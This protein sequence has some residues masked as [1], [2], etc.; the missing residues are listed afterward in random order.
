MNTHKC[1]LEA[2]VI[3]VTVLFCSCSTGRPVSASALALCSAYRN[4]PAAASQVYNNRIVQ[5]EG[6]VCNLGNGAN[7]CYVLLS[8]DVDDHG[9]DNQV[10]CNLDRTEVS[11]LATIK[12]YSRIRLTGKIKESRKYSTGEAVVMVDCKFVDDPQNKISACE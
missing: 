5:V 8:G 6:I 7:T 1:F 9:T 2:V 10:I 12:Q 3:A 11:R 4:D